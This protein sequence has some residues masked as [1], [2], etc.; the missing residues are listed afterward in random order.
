MVKQYFENETDTATSSKGIRSLID[1]AVR[2]HHSELL[3]K[4]VLDRDM[5]RYM[6]DLVCRQPNGHEMLTDPN[7]STVFTKEIISQRISEEGFTPLMI[8]VKYRSSQCVMLLLDNKYCDANVLRQSS[9]DFE[10]TVLHICAEFPDEQIT[11]ALMNKAKALEIDLGPIDAMGNT[12]LHICAQK[13]NFQMCDKLLPIHES[14]S[15]N[16][17]KMLCIKNN[18]GLTALHEAIQNEYEAIIDRIIQSMSDPEAL[19]DQCDAE[20][21]TPLHMAALKGNVKIVDMLI[22][23]NAN[24]HAC[25]VNDHTPLHEAA[26][27]SDGSSEENRDRV[28]CMEHLIAANAEVNVS[29]I[30]RESPL[31]IACRYSSEPLVRALLK[32][33]ANILQTNTQGFNCLEVAIEEQNTETVGYLI[34]HDCIFE[35]LRNAQFKESSSQ[36]CRGTAKDTDN[37]KCCI[38]CCKPNGCCRVMRRVADTPMRKLIVTMPDMALKILDKCTTTIGSDKSKIHRIFFDYEFLE[39]QYAVRN[40]AKGKDH[41]RRPSFCSFLCKE[42]VTIPI[43]LRRPPVGML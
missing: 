21:R 1:A 30:H 10:R 15:K 22:A 8:A 34:D 4:L 40:W 12:P 41:P 43:V 5:H 13:N 9:N 36:L 27:W 2:Y 28:E 17:D 11:D 38:P 29:S 3:S 26:R 7:L 37:V 31:H 24:V 39:D 42:T 18:N 20:L 25:D 14:D 33:D 32:H 35:L 23:Y 6:L 19:V 16:I